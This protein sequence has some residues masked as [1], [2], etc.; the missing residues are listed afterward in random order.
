MVQVESLMDGHCG[1]LGTVLKGRN[2]NN[3]GKEERANSAQT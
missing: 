2:D 1:M 3:G